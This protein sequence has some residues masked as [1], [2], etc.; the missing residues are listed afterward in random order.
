MFSW[1]GYIEQIMICPNTSEPNILYGSISS[2]LVCAFL[3]WLWKFYLFFPEL[4]KQSHIGLKSEKYCLRGK[5]MFSWY[6]DF[7]LLRYDV[8][9]K[10]RDPV[11]TQNVIRETHCS[12]FQASR[13]WRVVRNKRAGKIHLFALSPR[14]KRLEQARL[15]GAGALCFLI[16]RWT[17]INLRPFETL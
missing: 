17:Y 12:L 15:P 8:I 1:L 13:Q 5:I 4:Q 16:R 9:L 2:C 11:V 7:V 3:V 14:S 10:A 6:P